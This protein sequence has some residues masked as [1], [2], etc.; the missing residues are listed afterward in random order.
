MK[1]SPNYS[2]QVLFLDGGREVARV[3][4]V[5]MDATPGKDNFIYSIPNNALENNKKYKV[6]LKK[7]LSITQERDIK[8]EDP[9]YTQGTSAQTSKDTLLLEYEFTTSRFSSFAQKIAYYNQPSVA[10]SGTNVVHTLA[11]NQRDIETNATED[12]TTLETNGKSVEGTRYS[13]ALVQSLGADLSQ[14][15]VIGNTPGG[16]QFPTNV[17]YSYFGSKLQVQ[18]DVFSEVQK[19]NQ[20]LR[21]TGIQCAVQNNQATCNVG[22]GSST[23]PKGSV[24]YY[25]LGYFLPGKNIKTSEVVLSFTLPNDVTV[26]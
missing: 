20:E 3:T 12:F 1:L 14:G 22:N 2:Y 7:I 25:K 26:Q 24:Y 21:T 8:L 9:S 10:A 15:F 6:Q 23:F 17:A 11:P 16:K 4:N 19:I 5:T 13:K 18:Y